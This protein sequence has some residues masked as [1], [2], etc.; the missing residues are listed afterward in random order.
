LNCQFCKV[1]V[2][3][4]LFANVS[5]KPCCRSCYQKRRPEKKGKKR[6]SD[7]MYSDG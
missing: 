3:D 7:S 1:N 2:A 5:Q 4:K 6:E